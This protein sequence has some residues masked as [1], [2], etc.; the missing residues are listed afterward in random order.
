MEELNSTWSK[1][2]VEQKD[3]IESMKNKVIGMETSMEEMRQKLDVKS[4]EVET[5]EEKLK[6]EVGTY[7]V[8]SSVQLRNFLPF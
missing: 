7:I 3:E 8:L 5:L 2:I 4:S 6:T 1:N